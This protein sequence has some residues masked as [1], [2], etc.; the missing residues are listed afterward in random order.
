VTFDDRGSL[1]GD[2][3]ISPGLGSSERKYLLL[4]RV[5]NFFEDLAVLV[6]EG[7][8]DMNLST[9]TSAISYS[10]NGLAGK[11]RPTGFARPRSPATPRVSRVERLVEKLEAIDPPAY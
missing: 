9:E 8:L 1:P 10:A 5:P 3:K 11:K 7:G 2:P 4:T 6:E